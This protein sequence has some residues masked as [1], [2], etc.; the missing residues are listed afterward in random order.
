MA[1][2]VSGHYSGLVDCSGF[3]VENPRMRLSL[4]NVFQA[5]DCGLLVHLKMLFIKDI[6]G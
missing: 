3:T 2:P 5:K 4:S 1:P 6:L